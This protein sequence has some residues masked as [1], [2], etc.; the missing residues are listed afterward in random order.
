LRISRKLY[1]PGRELALTESPDAE[2]LAAYL[3]SR[4]FRG[5]KTATAE[6]LSGCGDCDEVF[7]D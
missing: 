3:E 1:T 2:A 4:L 5:E 6:H 7:I